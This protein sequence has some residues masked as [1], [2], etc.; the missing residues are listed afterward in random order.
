MLKFLQKGLLFSVPLLFIFISVYIIDPYYLYHKNRLFN[1]TIYDI[2]YSFDQGRR[3]KIISYLNNPKPNIIL[4]ASEINL[5]HERNIPEEG[6]HSLSFG[7]APLQESV[8]IF[9]RIVAEHNI[10]KIILAPEFIKFYNDCIGEYYTWGS[11]QSAKAYELYDNKLDYLLDKNAIKSAWYYLLSEF[12][13]ENSSNK[14]KMTKEEFWQHQLSYAEGQYSQIVSENEFEK[15]FAKLRNIASY[16][17]K[18]NIEVQVVIPIQHKD[19]TLIEFNEISYSI[20]KRYLLSLIKTFGKVYYFD[21]PN[22]VSINNNYFSDPF[23]YTDESTYINAI[24]HSDDSLCIIMEKEEDIE[25]LD[26]IRN[27]YIKNY[28]YE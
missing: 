27:A 15:S 28:S 10:K 17:K 2:D 12:G 1:Q 9:W 7:G 23:H 14:P 22:R 11:S 8:D 24:W 6:W 13:I 21:Y 5:I 26:S 20:Y 4:G 3:F 16:C 25:I 19:L 18:H